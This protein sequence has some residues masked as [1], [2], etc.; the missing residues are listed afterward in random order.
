MPKLPNREQGKPYT[1]DQVVK[2]L[3]STPPKPVEKKPKKGV[4]SER[5]TGG[6][7]GD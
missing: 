3:V 1:F 5:K 6:A 2:Q 7:A 4:K